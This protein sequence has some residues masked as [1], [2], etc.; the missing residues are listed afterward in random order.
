MEMPPREGAFHHLRQMSWWAINAQEANSCTSLLSPLPSERADV[1]PE[2]VPGESGARTTIIPRS[3]G[4]S[5][6]L[7]E[8]DI[9]EAF[10]IEARAYPENTTPSKLR[11][12]FDGC[13]IA[14]QQAI[15]RPSSPARL[16]LP[17]PDAAAPAWGRYTIPYAAEKRNFLDSLHTVGSKRQSWGLRYPSNARSPHMWG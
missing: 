8:R 14:R 2:V 3:Q 4:K 9:Q 17:R 1:R 7:R 11:K 10:S 15:R 6:R 12:A 5:N 13:A 16:E